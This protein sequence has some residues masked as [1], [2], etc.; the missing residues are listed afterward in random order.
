[1]LY[2]GGKVRHYNKLG[3]LYKDVYK[4]Y[5]NINL[6]SRVNYISSKACHL[7]IRFAYSP[8]PSLPSNGNSPPVLAF[9]LQRPTDL[10]C[11]F[12]S[13]SLLDLLLHRLGSP[14]SSPPRV[15]WLWGVYIS[16]RRCL[17]FFLTYTPLHPTQPSLPKNIELN[18]HKSTMGNCPVEG[19]APVENMAI[20]VGSA[21]IQFFVSRDM[22]Y[23][24]SAFFKKAIKDL[25]DSGKRIIEMIDRDPEIFGIY[26]GS[27]YNGKIIMF[28]DV[29]HDMYGEPIDEAH[30]PDLAD[31]WPP[32]ENKEWIRWRNCYVLGEFLGDRDFQD[33]CIDALTDRMHDLE[34]PVYGLAHDIYSHSAAASEHRKLPVEL[35][36]HGSKGKRH[37]AKF[38]QETHGCDACKEFSVDV[39]QA[40][41]DDENF[42]KGNG[43]IKQH[44]IDD[45]LKDDL[46]TCR[47][48]DHTRLKKPCYKDK[49]K[50]HG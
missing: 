28:E 23:H 31:L 40:L 21:R 35:F 47:F 6:K 12:P 7:Q 34:F 38:H 43:K 9:L 5:R 10:E 18:L 26:V 11:T 44:D 37:L 14:P 17:Y 32:P 29:V 16:S 3:K 2:A 25:D 41:V 45:L 20:V 15:S 50:V 8:S 24:R 13:P 27:L 19:I 22:V 30:D 39:V 48:H 49:S 46:D 33:A 4:H 36:I 42:Q 1:M